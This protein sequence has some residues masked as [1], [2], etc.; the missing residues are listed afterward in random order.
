MFEAITYIYSGYYMRPI[1]SDRGRKR[2]TK[3]RSCWVYQREEEEQEEVD[4]V[5][6]AHTL[7]YVLLGLVESVK[8]Y[9]LTKLIRPML[10]I[11]PLRIMRKGEH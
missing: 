7:F 9:T 5:Y 11:S 8:G 6:S 10:L 2:E 3:R 1:V 4:Q